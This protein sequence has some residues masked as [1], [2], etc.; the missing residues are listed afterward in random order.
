LHWVRTS[1]GVRRPIESRFVIDST[2]DWWTRSARR[3]TAT[4][5]WAVAASKTRLR[6][7]WDAE[8]F[9]DAPDDRRSRLTSRR[10]ICF[11]A[12]A[13]K[14]WSVP[15]YSSRASA[16]GAPSVA[17]LS[18]A[19]VSPGQKPASR[20]LLPPS[21]LLRAPN[22]IVDHA[23]QAVDHRLATADT[24]IKA[25]KGGW[26]S[27]YPFMNA[28]SDQTIK[29]RE[30]FSKTQR[31]LM[32]AEL[33]DFDS[34][35]PSR[36]EEKLDK[37]LAGNKFTGEPKQ[38]KQEEIQDDMERGMWGKW[39]PRLKRHVTGYNYGKGGEVTM[40]SYNK[41]GTPVENRLNKLGITRAAGVG[42]TFG[43]YTSETE[44]R[45]LVNWGRRFEPKEYKL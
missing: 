25:D 43:C 38:Q 17:R 7:P 16:A 35:D 39:V 9:A 44:I 18:R 11:E 40:I 5:P 29:V 19:A 24:S 2:G 12:I 13:E 32:K 37:W 31:S 15:Y 14:P 33:A 30:Y 20:L 3:R 45:K 34:V 28:V 6:R 26:I 23:Q 41:P 1:A 10:T 27:F 8:W 4:M 36:L 22:L 21:L 42:A